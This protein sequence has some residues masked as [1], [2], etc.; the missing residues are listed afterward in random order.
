[1][2]LRIEQ[3]FCDNYIRKHMHE[4]LPWSSQVLIGAGGGSEKSGVDRM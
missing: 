3:A 1:M 4:T 2:Q